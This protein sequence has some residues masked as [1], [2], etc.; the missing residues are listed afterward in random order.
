[1]LSLAEE[2]P[3]QAKSEY[4]RYACPEWEAR[5]YGSWPEKVFRR[6]TFRSIGQSADGREASG[7]SLLNVADTSTT[8]GEYKSGFFSKFFLR[9][10]LHQS[11]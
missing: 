11:L 5:R 3:D 8:G 2:S 4:Q 6:E 1:L 10:E 9:E 7:N